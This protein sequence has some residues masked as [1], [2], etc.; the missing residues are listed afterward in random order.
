[1]IRD[2]HYDPETGDLLYCDFTDTALVSVL[3]GNGD[4]TFAAPSTY[5]LEVISF[6]WYGIGPLPDVGHFDVKVGDVNEDGRLDV[7]TANHTYNSMSVL[8]GNGEGMLQPPASFG[9]TG[10]GPQALAL[11]DLNEDGKLDL[12]TANNGG[13]NVSVMLGNFSG[14]L[15]TY[16]VGSAPVSVAIADFNG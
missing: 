12:V 9:F 3:L 11:G 13:N 10:S 14:A 6:V 16:A 7:V 5:Q 4:G 15:H 2:C 8:L 1:S